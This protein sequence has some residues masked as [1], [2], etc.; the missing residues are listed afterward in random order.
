MIGLTIRFVP[1]GTVDWVTTTAKQARFDAMSSA[2]ASKYYR[3][4]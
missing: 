4:A 1:T 2:A 3:S